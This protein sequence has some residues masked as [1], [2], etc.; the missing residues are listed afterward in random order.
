MT[1]EEKALL[2]HQSNWATAYLVVAQ[3]HMHSPRGASSA[4]APPSSPRRLD[5]L[6]Y[7]AWNTF[8]VDVDVPSTSRDVHVGMR[9]TLTSRGIAGPGLNT[10]SSE[11]VTV[12][13]DGTDEDEDE[14]ASDYL[15]A[16][17]RYDDGLGGAGTRAEHPTVLVALGD[18]TTTRMLSY[19]TYYEGLSTGTI[20]LLRDQLQERFETQASDLK[21]YV[22]SKR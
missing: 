13:D 17:W 6:S 21:A 1:S 18:G 14:D 19:E 22:E 2:L 20:A 4:S 9:M 5:F 16:A 7:G 12:L 15:L 3:L 11:I 10:T 8:I